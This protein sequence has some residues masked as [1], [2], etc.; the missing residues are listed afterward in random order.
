[1]KKILFLLLISTFTTEAN[2]YTDQAK[3]V[4]IHRDEWG[5]PHIYGKTDADAVFGLMYAQCE[6]D[7]ARVEMNYIEKLG[8]MS[9][10]KG[11]KELAYDLY[12]KLLIDEKEAKAE[13]KTAPVWLKKLLNAYADGI[14]YYLQKHP[15]VKPRLITH[16]EPWYP[17][18]WTDGS[19]GAISTGDVTEQETALFYGLP[20]QVAS[21]KYQTPDEKLT[22]S[23]GFAVG[24]ALSKSG[25]SLL[26]INPHVTFYFRPEVHVES[27]EGLSVYGAVTWGQ[28][29]V[30][31]GFN[32]YNGWMHTSSEVDVADAYIETTRSRNGQMEYLLDGKWIP[33][34]TKIITLGSRKIKAYFNHRGPVLAARNGKWISVRSYNR[35]R[36][37]L[38]QSWLR[39]KTKG[40]EDYKRVMDMRANTSNNTVY[41]D[42]KGNIAYWHGNYVP[43][44][45]AT[46]DWGVPQDG[47]S[48][49][50]D[51]K[52]LHSVDEIVHVYNPASGWIQNCNSTPYTVSG[53]SSP[54]RTNYPVYMAPDGENFRDRNA[55]RLFSQTG[56]L[57]LQGLIGLGY[58]RRLMAFET[59]LPALVNAASQESDLGEVVEELK[60]WDYNASTSSIPQTIAIRWGLKILPKIPKPKQFGGETEVIQN[61]ESY[62]RT[63]SKLAMAQALREVLAELKRDF[64][65]WHVAWGDLNRFQR[66]SNGDALQMDDSKASIPVPFTS[67]AW[68][69]LP[70]YTSR[71]IQGSKKWYGVNGNSFI[72][73]VE[74]GPKIKAYSLL[75]GGQNGDPTSPHFFDQ[76][77]MYAEGKFK[78]IYFYK[79]DVL[80]HAVVS[81][82]P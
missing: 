67:S 2:P 44:R 40:L 29:F 47:S 75:A 31:Q 27:E 53:T 76:G 30:Y 60:K 28:F 64:G 66:V 1:M 11:E 25:H 10:V 6:D 23:N 74:F 81:Y 21:V 4:T 36:K 12:I 59:L 34:Q 77:Q 70:S 62:A 7:F 22:G 37:S 45:D 8:R 43:R 33:F 26:Y 18:L 71:S 14:N 56:K 58:D 79:S 9:E 54:L 52:G 80:K 61:M 3:R 65:T 19:I 50:I 82:H 46:K 32:P 16:F 63:G 24:P 51:W 48:S 68:G 42:N 72:A 15:E 55:V 78:D 39:T 73:A 38:M 13:Y 20:A 69:Q 41:A 49:Q 17:L 57:D 35:A 5:I